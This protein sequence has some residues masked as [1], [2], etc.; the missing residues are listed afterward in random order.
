MVGVRRGS[1]GGAWGGGLGGD[2]GHRW[3]LGG[4]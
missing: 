3:G 4:W 1:G 2:G